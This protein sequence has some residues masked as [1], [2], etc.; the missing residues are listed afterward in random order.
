[1]NARGT[2]P[3]V[4]PQRRGPGGEHGLEF[5]PGPLHLALGDQLRREGVPQLDQ[6]LDVEGRIAQQVIAQRPDR[7]VVGRMAF[8]QVEPEDLFHQRAESDPRVAEQPPGQ[9]GVEELARP[10]AD[11][12]EARQVL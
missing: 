2:P 5:L 12:G 3:R 4:G 7:P 6:D 1:V 11:L 8:L 10:E 9:L